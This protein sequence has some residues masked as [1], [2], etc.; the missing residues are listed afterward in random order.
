VT[1]AAT[2]AAGIGAA[3]D[4]RSDLIGGILAAAGS[5]QFGT[6]V[7]LGKRVLERGM[8]AESMLAFRF[9]VAAIVL[10]VALVLLRRPLVAVPGE[11]TALTLLAMF[12]YAVE[13][14]FFF[15]AVQHGTAA[16]VTLLFYLYPVVV[17]V[18]AWLVGRG[19][20]AFPTI[21]ALVLAVTGAGI[22]VS[23]GSGLAVA[24]TGVVFA[25]AAAVTFSGYLIGSDILLRRT[26]PWTSAMWVSAG[27][28]LG[29]FAYVAA[30]GRYT[31][32]A[33]AADWWSVLAMGVATSG[34]FVCLMGA[35]QR[36]G[37]V[38][39]SIVSA[40]EPLGAAVLGYLFLHETVG[41]GTVL[42][43]M[44]ILSAAVLASVARGVSP[45]EQQIT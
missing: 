11:R 3:R 26:S 36:I 28:S 25:L 42:G 8:T 2:P 17:T 34:A 30:T 1:R 4:R 23:T 38:R 14:T 37:A 19:A 21:L 13:A 22:V 9:G 44:L 16:A 24:T 15:T 18:G 32:P 20:P 43:G 31:A 45:H 5:L 33:V 12:G 7:V 41:L 29:L 35:L 6:V 39:T 40:T 27:A 10:L